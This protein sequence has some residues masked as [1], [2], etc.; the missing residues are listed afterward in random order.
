MVRSV[1][2]F[3]VPFK[4]MLSNPGTPPRPTSYADRAGLVF[5]ALLWVRFARHGEGWCDVKAAFE[6]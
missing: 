4:N 6:A 3:L 2:L 5:R 1:M